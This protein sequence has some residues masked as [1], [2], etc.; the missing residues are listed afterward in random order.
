[1]EGSCKER[2][3]ELEMTSKFPNIS[4]C[5]AVL[6]MGSHQNQ[7]K[8]LQKSRSMHHSSEKLHFNYGV[9]TQAIGTLK[10]INQIVSSRD[11]NLLT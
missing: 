8:E 2:G 10:C 6:N 7:L 4:V 11:Q 1:M 3:K 5:L 9:N